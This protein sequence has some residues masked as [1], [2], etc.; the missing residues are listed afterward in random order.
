MVLDMLSRALRLIRIFHDI[1]QNELAEKLG[2][3]RSY[4]SEI[5]SGKKSP[6]LE[7]VNKYSEYFDIPASSILF[8]SEQLDN[9]D[10]E[11]NKSEKMRLMLATN[12]L[13]ILEFIE[14]VSGKEK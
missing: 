8:F 4:L 6:S 10:K 3:S 1:K 12:A 9:T 13:A 14:R 11:N 5:E 7:I 2:V